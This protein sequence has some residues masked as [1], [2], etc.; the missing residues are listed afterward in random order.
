MK[1]VL[2]PLSLMLYSIVS[3]SQNASL[4]MS[5][6]ANWNP[7]TITQYNDIWG[8]MDCEGN[9]YAI[10]GSKYEIHFVDVSDH[11]NPLEIA[12]FT[13][14]QGTTWRDIKSYRNRAYAVSDNLSLI[15]I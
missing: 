14:G 12:S 13:G 10:L 4:N 7:D 2:L 5:L 9:E 6:L 8:H 1:S 3:F 11:S 15:H